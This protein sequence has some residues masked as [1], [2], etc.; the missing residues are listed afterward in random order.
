[1]MKKGNNTTQKSSFGDTDSLVNMAT[2][3]AAGFISL[4]TVT[5]L[6]LLSMLLQ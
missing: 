1:M 2:G 4:F 3:S 5:V 6:I